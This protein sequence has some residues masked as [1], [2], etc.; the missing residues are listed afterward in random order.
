MH[1]LWKVAQ[2]YDIRT[3]LGELVADT[4][5]PDADNSRTGLPASGRENTTFSDCLGFPGTCPDRLV[6]GVQESCHHLGIGGR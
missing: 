6:F 1:L 4:L 5:W 2:T 3:F